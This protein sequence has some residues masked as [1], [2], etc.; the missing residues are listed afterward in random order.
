MRYAD[1]SYGQIVKVLNMLRV[2]IFVLSMI[3]A[4]ISFADNS[5]PVDTQASDEA[6]TQQVDKSLQEQSSQLKEAE[7]YKLLYENSK[8]ANKRLIST[9]HWSISLVATFLFALFG[10]QIFFNL[11]LGK[12]E[13]LCLKNEFDEKITSANS[14]LSNKLY[15]LNREQEKEHRKELESYKEK[16]DKSVKSLISAE[17]KSLQSICENYRKDNELQNS[18]FDYKIKGIK[19]DLEKN[20]GDIWE[21]KGVKSNALTR[22]INTSLLENELGHELKYSLSDI[23]QLL[24]SQSD[25]HESDKLKL[26]ELVGKLSNRYESYKDAI[27]SKLKMLTIYKFVDDPVNFGKRIRKN[28]SEV[29][30]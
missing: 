10:S 24:Y 13:I 16:S 14:E 9:M 8:D 12:E 2:I 4:S 28:I 19:I 21:L 22:Y 6:K 18:E 5:L 20:I 30:A 17:R 11:R 27:V 3:S 26:D 7:L 1:I 23:I 15:L 29:P 25:I